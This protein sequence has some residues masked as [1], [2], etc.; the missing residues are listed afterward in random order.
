METCPRC[1]VQNQPRRAACWN[2]FGPL[3]GGGAAT[4]EDVEVVRVPRFSLR[5]PWKPI[6]GILIVAGLAYGGLKVVKGT[7]AQSIAES[8]LD[9][10][11]VGDTE[12]Q[13]KLT[14]GGTGGLP[15]LEKGFKLKDA[16]T[17]QPATVS[18]DTAEVMASL[19]IQP[20]T[21]TIT[22]EGAAD[23]VAALDLL[24]AP[25]PATI[26]LTK[27]GRAWKVDQDTTARRLKTQMEKKLTPELM[28]KLGKVRT[29]PTLGSATPPGG[30]APIAPPAPPS[31]A[32]DN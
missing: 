32:S 6:L 21:Q 17:E 1:G 2:C 5:I 9:A 30:A 25:V 13:N 26:S 24:K 31:D 29:P 16:T 7:S 11:V 10:L 8:Y 18:G 4:A 22:A 14:R 3:E 20:D 27:E 23:L 28:E 19:T 12:R 15:L